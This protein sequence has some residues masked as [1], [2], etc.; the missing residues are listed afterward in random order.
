[1]PTI[2]MLPLICLSIFLLSCTEKKSVHSAQHEMSGL[3]YMGMGE[4]S[5]QLKLKQDSAVFNNQTELLAEIEVPAQ[6]I[7]D[8][9]FKWKLGPDV[10]LID[11]DL[12]GV[13]KADLQNTRFTFKIKIENFKNHDQRFVRFEAVGM[14]KK[15]SIYTDG[16]ISS[17]IDKSF[18][19]T[20]QKVEKFNA[21]K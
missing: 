7:G 10:T 21:E 1:M 14:T 15:Q 17:T 13:I 5:I 19:D 4:R 20:V 6:Y 11:G 8:I 3:S 12:A 16:I 2:K 18:E 9:R